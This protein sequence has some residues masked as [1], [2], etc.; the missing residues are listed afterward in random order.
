MSRYAMIIIGSIMFLCNTAG[1]IELEEALVNCYNNNEDIKAAQNKFLS[2]VEAFPQALSGFLPD[3]NASI[4]RSDTSTK[5]KHYSQVNPADQGGLEKG[6]TISQPVFNGG[7]DVAALKAAQE[8]FKA[9]RAEYYS[10][11]QNAIFK[12]IQ[13]YLNYYSSQKKYD[14]SDTSVQSN[15]KQLESAQ[16]RLKL[17]EV[18]KTDVAAAQYAFDSSIAKRFQAY[19]ELEANKAK[20]IEQTGIEPVDITLPKIPDNIPSSLEDLQ[21]KSNTNLDIHNIQHALYSTKAS[22][23][24]EKANLLPSV[25]FQ[26]K[27]STS[28]YDPEGN[29]LRSGR[30]IGQLNSTTVVPQISLQVPIYSRGGIEYS[31]IRQQ[32]KKTRAAVIQLDNVRKQ[33]KTGCISLW[34]K[35]NASKSAIVATTSGVEA[36]Q[37]AYDGVVQE[38][39]LGSK[40]MMDVL[41]A[42][43]KLNTARLDKVHNDVSY[44]MS[45]YEMQ[46]LIG[47][48]TA[49]SMKLKT[50][51][52]N[53]E[54][55]FKKIKFKI[56]GY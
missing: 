53:P 55:E 16:E 7:R 18:T 27:A 24:S 4:T 10:S 12:A 2:N 42:E 22:E 32:K 5:Y 41:S 13:T 37:S 20:F 48:L 9:A 52:F 23:L 17:G 29:V 36:A 50:E 1:G 39:L 49:K 14:I 8:G 26:L 19:S 38:Q 33:L 25:V 40:T 21:A 11:E 3:I 44:I 31:K 28:N 43:E 30:T 47:Q 34:A 45:A 6:I 46:S 51:Y 54:R 15:Q 56:I 35:F